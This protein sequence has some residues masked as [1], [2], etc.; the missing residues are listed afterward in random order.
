MSKYAYFDEPRKAARK[1]PEEPIEPGEEAIL[2]QPME[3]VNA[4]MVPILAI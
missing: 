3:R 1:R 4:Q 2:T